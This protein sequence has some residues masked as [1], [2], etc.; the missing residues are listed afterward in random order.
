M[1]LLSEFLSSIRLSGSIFFRAEFGAPWALSSPDSAQ[2]AQA[3][4]PAARQMVLFHAIQAGE[5]WVELEGRP[6]QPLSAGDVV[7]FPFG[8]AHSMGAGG[9]QKIESIAMLFPGPPPWT[10]PPRIAYGGEGETTQIVCGFL[11]VDKALF[12]PLLS[13]LPPLLVVKPDASHCGSMVRSSI[14]FLS[15]ELD[16]GSPGSHSVLG[17]L[18]ELLFV[19][20]LRQHMAQLKT[21]ELGWLAALKDDGIR[22]SLEL[23]HAE[24][25]EPWSVEE[26]A[27]RAGMSRSGF[28][29]RFNELLGEAPGQYLTRWRIQLASQRLRDTD[30]SI[31]SVA[32]KVGYGS[33]SAFS[34]AFKRE[35]GRGPAD[36]RKALQKG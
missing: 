27:K 29:A 26:L 13:S 16:N 14:E 19:E 3:L 4:L 24:P 35:A 18:T 30:E 28:A 25:A 9:A 10:T 1:D 33:E 15:R 23:I 22:R 5:C 12:N 7:L 8:H 6:Q 17:R 20:V 34:R 31:A 32:A 21:S 11:H 36:F 2:L